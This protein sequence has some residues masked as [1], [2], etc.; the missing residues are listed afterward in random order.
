MGA[1]FEQHLGVAVAAT[2]DAFLAKLAA[3]L[4]VIV[5]LAVVD[6]DETAVRRYHRLGAAR[7]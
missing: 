4:A 7:R 6:D 1:A 5:D 3:Q 2:P